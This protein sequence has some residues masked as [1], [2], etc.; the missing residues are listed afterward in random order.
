MNANQSAE[1]AMSDILFQLTG[2]D[3]IHH[4]QVRVYSKI[5]RHPVK[6]VVTVTFYALIKP[7][8]HPVIA[9]NYISDVQWFTLSQVPRLGFDHNQIVEDALI[10]LRHNLRDHLILGELLPKKFTLKELQELFESIL[11]ENLDRRNFRKKMLQLDLIIPTG[12]KKIGVK[13]GPE[14]FTMK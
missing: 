1:E 7:E 5:D 9:K 2:L 8:N 13:G 14:L 10:Q 6:R 4:E 11:G 12:E 3:N